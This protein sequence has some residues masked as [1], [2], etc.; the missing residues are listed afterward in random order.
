M[1]TPRR[2]AFV[3]FTAVILA[4]ALRAADSPTAPKCGVLF[5]VGGVGGVDPLQ[6]WAQ[7]A[8][9][10]AGVPHEIRIFEWTHGKLRP[11]R[12]LQD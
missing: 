2:I 11:L 3:L 12:D 7:V 4:S 1:N 10:L 5:V 9:P 8:L 6:R